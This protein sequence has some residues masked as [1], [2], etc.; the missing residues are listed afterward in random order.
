MIKIFEKSE[1]QQQKVDYFVFLVAVIVKIHKKLLTP[2]KHN[3]GLFL[4]P[5]I[6]L[7]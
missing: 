1:N 3:A 5:L 6:V 7:K 4:H 2:S